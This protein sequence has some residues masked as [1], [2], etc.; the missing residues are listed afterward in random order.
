ML[1]HPRPPLGVQRLKGASWTQR[2]PR[3]TSSI[4]MVSIFDT[5]N[6]PQNPDPNR[7]SWAARSQTGVLSGSGA[8]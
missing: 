2:K 6:P 1:H 7:D 5:Q 8:P 3:V 4:P